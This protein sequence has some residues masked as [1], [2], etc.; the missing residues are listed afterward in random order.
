MKIAVI[1]ATFPELRGGYVYKT[2]RGRGSNAARATARACADL[3]RQVSRRRVTVF[4]ATV[5]IFEEAPKAQPKVP[6]VT[7]ATAA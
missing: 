1:Q 6:K 7:E 5:S 3:F 2:G 4:K